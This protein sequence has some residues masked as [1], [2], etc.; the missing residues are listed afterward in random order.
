MEYFNLASASIVILISEYTDLQ[1]KSP[2]EWAGPCPLCGGEDRFIVWPKETGGRYWCRQCERK[3]DETQFCVDFLGMTMAD[4]LRAT[5]KGHKLS[6]TRPTFSTKASAVIA[7]Q[8]PVNPAQLAENSLVAEPK[9]KAELDRDIWQTKAQDEMRKWQGGLLNNPELMDWLEKDRGLAAE[10]VRH[11]KLGYQPN[12]YVEDRTVWGFAPDPTKSDKNKLWFQPGL[13]IPHLRPDGNVSGINIR[14]FKTTDAVP[15]RYRPFEEP[16]KP[17]K[18]VRGTQSYPWVLAEL[19]P[20]TGLVI[21]V[22]SELDALL[23]W[24]YLDLYVTPVALLTAGAKPA[25]G[26]LPPGPV[27]FAL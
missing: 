9:A 1:Q 16:Q 23:L 19:H 13:V 8:R 5:G 25:P 10:T 26:S 27:M 11:W 24:Q 17:Y 7:V 2:T 20:I 3:G 14:Q 12:Y 22:E 15:Q 21:V 6:G 4:A 18:R